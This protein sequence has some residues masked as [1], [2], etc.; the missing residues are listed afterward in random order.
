MLVI[1]QG[2]HNPGLGD[3]EQTLGR[4]GLCIYLLMK[5]NELSRNRVHLFNSGT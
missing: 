2:K 4:D 3:S 1:Y 5:V